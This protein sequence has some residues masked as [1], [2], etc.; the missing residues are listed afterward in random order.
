M[1]NLMTSM[2]KALFLKILEQ[3]KCGR[4]IQL[5]HPEVADRVRNGATYKDIAKYLDSQG[6]NPKYNRSNLEGGVGYAIRGY[7]GE[8]NGIDAY[9][10]LIPNGEERNEIANDKHSNVGKY[11]KVNKIGIFGRNEYQ[12][13]SDASNA[14]KVGGKASIEL[15]YGFSGMGKIK[16]KIVSKAGVKAR[17]LVP[18][19][20]PVHPVLGYNEENYLLQTI[21]SNEFIIK[22]GPNRGRRDLKGLSKHLN[23]EYHKGEEVRKPSSVSSKIDKLLNPSF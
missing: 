11:T 15:G 13:I 12:R 14:G 18:W 6:F 20:G 9:E 22:S 21:L 23:H 16:R 7:S 5:E 17:G 4:L 3:I 1:K 2:K 10:G 8:I 19:N